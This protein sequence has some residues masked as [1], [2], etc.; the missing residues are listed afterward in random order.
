MQVQQLLGMWPG[1]NPSSA[2][3][4]APT[5]AQRSL[6]KCWSQERREGFGPRLH[7]C[8]MGPASLSG[9]AEVAGKESL[10]GGR[11]AWILRPLLPGD[12]LLMLVLSI[13]S[14]FPHT[15]KFLLQTRPEQI[16]YHSVPW[17]LQ[18]KSKLALS[19]F[20]ETLPNSSLHCQQTAL[21]FLRL[22]S[23]NTPSCLTLPFFAKPYSP[24][25][26]CH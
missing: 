13:Q 3:T 8:L 6:G 22:S 7:P 11:S 18:G 4:T 9:G 12:I 14:L 23:P 24:H 15:D 16:Y 25:H 2:E 20:L 19:T 21:S 1:S 17:A 5:T 26:Q 10:Q